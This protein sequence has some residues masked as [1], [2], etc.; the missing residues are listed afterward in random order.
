[1]AKYDLC[2]VYWPTVSFSFRIESTDPE[3][4][5]A[6]VKELDSKWPKFRSGGVKNDAQE[7]LEA[8]YR[9]PTLDA[10]PLFGPYSWAIK[11][12]CHMGW[13][14]FAVDNRRTWFRRKT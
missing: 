9:S 11:W 1:M 8:T 2:E 6:L 14:P 12:L 5:A 4:L 10:N 13:E 7:V 3:S